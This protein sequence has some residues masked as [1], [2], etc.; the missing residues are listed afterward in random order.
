MVFLIIDDSRPIHTLVCEML[1]EQ[2]IEFVHSYNGKEG[3][4]SARDKNPD[5]ILL[6]WEMPEMN[7]IEALEEIRKT[8]IEVPILMST[9]KNTM[10]DIVS[11]MQKGASDYLMKP[12]TKDILI[13]KI[14]Q[15]LGPK[16]N[17]K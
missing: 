17:L 16:G 6:D 5:L 11:A 8:N 7:G 13:G 2:G 14:N 3:V 4:T 9:T 12:F 1:G 10:N 15:V